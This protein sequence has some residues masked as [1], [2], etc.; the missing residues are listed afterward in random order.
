MIKPPILHRRTFLRGLG[1]AMALPMLE[2]M[3]PARSIAAAAAALVPTIV[4][5]IA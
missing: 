5:V 4:I 1:A 2:A 3:M